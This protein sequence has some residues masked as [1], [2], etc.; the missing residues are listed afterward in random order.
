VKTILEQGLIRIQYNRKRNQ[1][2]WTYWY[3]S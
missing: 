3:I 2:I 1:F